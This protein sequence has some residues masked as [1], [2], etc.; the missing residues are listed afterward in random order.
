ME[1]HRKVLRRR[2]A[3]LLIAR[4]LVDDVPALHLVKAALCHN[5]C[6]H[7]HHRALVRVIIC[8]VA[9]LD[10]YVVH[11][12]QLLALALALRGCR[13]LLK[14][15][16]G[17]DRHRHRHRRA[18]CVWLGRAAGKSLQHVIF[19]HCLL[20]SSLRLL[21]AWRQLYLVVLLALVHRAVSV[22]LV[23]HQLEVARCGS[24]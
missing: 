10:V 14:L 4:A 9:A 11:L 22:A 23:P 13:Q 19:V 15:R 6:R 16:V 7:C 8:R 1:H 3:G 5:I 21:R 17:V 18:L 24:A 2:R 20:A 12:R